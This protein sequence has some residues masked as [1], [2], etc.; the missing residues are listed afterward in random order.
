MRRYK[1]TYHNKTADVLDV[2][3]TMAMSMNEAILKLRRR[4]FRFQIE[5]ITVG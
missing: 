1:I 5:T 3:E 4:R 2:F